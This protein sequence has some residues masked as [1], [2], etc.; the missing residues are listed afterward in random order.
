MA[1]AA[2]LGSL[3]DELIEVIASSSAQIDASRLHVLRESSLRKLRH[4]NFLRTN[5]FEVYAAL[6]GYEERFRVV[7]RE[8]LADALRDR[9]DA[10][11]QSSNRWT[12]DV[13]HLL[14][15]L[16]DQPVQKAKL[17]DL[18]RLKEPEVDQ[19]PELKWRDIAREDGWNQDREL[20][21]NV[22]FGGYSSDENS[23]HADNVSDASTQS[24]DTSPSST[25]SRLRRQP[26][27]Y[28]DHVESDVKPEDIRNSQDWRRRRK[29]DQRRAKRV[30]ISEIQLVREILFMLGRRRNNLFDSEGN[31]LSHIQLSQVSWQGFESVLLAAKNASQKLNILQKYVERRQEVPLLQKLQETIEDR[32]RSFDDVLAR[33]QTNLVDLHRDVIVSVLKLLDDIEPH[34]HPL[35]CLAD[36]IRQLDE[37]EDVH[38]F[39]YLELLYDSACTLQLG[40]DDST[41]RF[42]GELFFQCFELYLRPIRFWMDDGELIENDETFFVSS[43]P[44]KVPWSRIWTDQ[45]Q[46]KKKPGGG[47][48][49]P[50]FL[51]AAASKIF[52]TG[53]SVVVLK[54]LGKHSA[55]ERKKPES[56]T[57]V[58]FAAV[59]NLTPFPEIFTNMFDQWMQSKHHA[60]SAT[61]KRTLFEN[62]NLLSD[63]DVLQHI[64]LMCDGSRSDHFSNALFNNIDLLNTSWYD[65]FNLTEVAREAFEGLIEP[66]RLTVSISR[67][68]RIPHVRDVRRTVRQ[69][70]P[71]MLISYQLPWLSRIVLSDDSL[72]NYQLV[73]TFLLQL[74]RASKVLIKHRLIAERTGHATDE[75]EVYYGLRSKLL[76]FCNI[77][78]SYLS[79]LVLGPLVSDFRR[80]IQHDEDVDQILQSHSVFVKRMRDAACL[81]G[82]LDPIRQAILDV[83]DL[84]IRLQ[85][86][87]RAQHE[88]GDA[89]PKTGPGRNMKQSQEE[90]D[91]LL[92][93]HQDAGSITQDAE[94]DFQ[95]V[96]G[97][98]QTGYDRHLKFICGGLRGVARASGSDVASKWDILAEMLEAGIKEH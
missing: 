85:D 12:P 87:R 88:R 97:E 15:Q 47:L 27:D 74:R 23:N 9:L 60:A 65:R 20:W 6:D 38:P 96:L 80:K 59:S 82:K 17:S 52:T 22:D 98:I 25:E 3:T 28:T 19:E 76:W 10:L 2:Q 71:S 39:R 24:D 95:Q 81:G 84:A 69:G 77:L 58:E 37:S 41:Y 75:Q 50:S 42:I 66:H 16:A 21:R 48:Y 1:F 68:N 72:E 93:E 92:S 89:G 33:F 51:Q 31:P 62:S 86:A 56:A 18:Q 29:A 49:A 94:M 43:S 13:L 40:G 70:L 45:F 11:A 78:Q 54:M 30:V 34:L 5:Q 67:D 8:G 35:R 91:S 73:F 26:I 64:Y 61:L 46:L 44:T 57:R 36:V 83:F 4:H 7:N 79:T 63:L 90:E 32:L 53:K 14:L 55:T